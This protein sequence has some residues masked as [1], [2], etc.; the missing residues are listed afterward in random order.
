MSEPKKSGIID[1]FDYSN[2]L[3]LHKK[4]MKTYLVK[5]C[6]GCIEVPCFN[7]HS[8]Q[9]QRRLPVLYKSGL[10]N[11]RPSYCPKKNCLNKEF[12]MLA[13]NT[14]EIEYHP[15][16]YKTR[17]CKESSLQ[18]KCT[19]DGPSCSYSHGDPRPKVDPIQYNNFDVD[20]YKI[21]PCE[22]SVYHSHRICENY[23]NI[24]ERRRN[25][26]KHIYKPVICT[27]PDCDDVDCEYAHNEMEKLYHQDYYKTVPCV[28]F[29]C[30]MSFMCPYMHSYEYKQIED[31]S[32]AR[33]LAEIKDKMN[34]LENMLQKTADI[35]KN[36]EEYLC[37][38]CGISFSSSILSCGHLVCSN[39]LPESHCK[40]CNSPSNPVILIRGIND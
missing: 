14:E 22:I 15:L 37:T 28:S 21:Y 40:S 39:C 12:C 20:T 18:G 27:N 24:D 7:Y 38:D 1:Y 33:E 10:W 31:S 19:K 32:I 36:M 23:H 8:G 17:E 29:P 16:I 6:K 30:L 4:F 5:K 9:N 26:S 13:H 34:M 3:D 11:Y 2:E 35:E 25:P